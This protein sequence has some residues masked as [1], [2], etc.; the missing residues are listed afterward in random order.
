MPISK[1]LRAEFITLGTQLA[2]IYAQT[3]MVIMNFT[4]D[5]NFVDLESCAPS[6]RWRRLFDHV[7]NNAA[8]SE[9]IEGIKR[10]NPG[11]P[12]ILEMEESFKNEQTENV[13]NNLRDII[14]SRRCVLFLGPE[15][16]KVRVSDELIPFN[17]KLSIEF[18]KELDRRQIY[19]D[20]EQKFNLSYLID[21]FESGNPIL[22]K[23]E[24]FAKNV[25][26]SCVIDDQIF[27]LI[28]RLK[29]PLI[30][31][32]NPDTRLVDLFS[33]TRF[34]STYYD[35]SSNSTPEIMGNILG[36]PDITHVYNIYG[37][38][39]DPYSIVF[40]EKESVEFARKSYERN[41]L[42]PKVINETIHKCYGLFIG[43]D[44]RDWHL[45]ILFDVLDLKEKPKNYSITGIN[46]NYPEYMRE[47]FERQYDMKFIKNDIE[48]ILSSLI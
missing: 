3:S 9:L 35:F 40:T 10:T 2:P 30:V 1:K 4:I 7:E 26:D 11:N 41:P 48:T 17:R 15:I 20:Q 27:K 12:K 47:Y 34:P 37:S 42:I 22:G 44:F 25:Y 16:L 18:A 5:M 31:N 38:F 36:K 28:E 32:T 29:F 45:K 43:F 19:Y 14:A 23:T 8:I 24:N 39:D 13:I 6:E 21:R 46:N 33:K